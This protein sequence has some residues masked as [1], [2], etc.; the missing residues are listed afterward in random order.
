MRDGQPPRKRGLADALYT[1][2]VEGSTE[3]RP[4]PEDPALVE[5]QWKARQTV[6]VTGGC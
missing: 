5:S 3:G 2:R 1:D 4:M 6:H